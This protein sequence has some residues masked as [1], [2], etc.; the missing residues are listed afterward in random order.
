VIHVEG[1]FQRFDWSILGEVLGKEVISDWVLA[2]SLVEDIVVGK[3]FFVASKKLWIERKGSALELLSILLK[4]EVSHLITSFLVLN[5]IVDN[6]NSGV[7]R[8][9]E[10][11]SDLWSLLDDGTALLSESLSDSLGSNVLLWKIVK[12]HVVSVSLEHFIKSV[13]LN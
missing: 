3:L 9:E 6:N 1:D 10:V 5:W 7:E 12:V 13:F 4:L 8:S 11:S 2:W